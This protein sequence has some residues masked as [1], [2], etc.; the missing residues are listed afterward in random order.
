[1]YK[2]INRQPLRKAFLQCVDHILIHT[3]RNHKFVQIHR[4]HITY[5][6]ISNRRRS[7]I[8]QLYAQKR[9]AHDIPVAFIFHQKLH[10]C[11]YIFKLLHLIQ[12]YDRTAFLKRLFCHQTKSHKQI[13]CISGTAKQ[14]GKLRLVNKIQFHIWHSTFPEAFFYKICLTNLSRSRYEQSVSAALNP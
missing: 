1:M 8:I 14:C 5:T 10:S 9:T 4:I 13:L 3:N 7:E 11:H 6:Q 2:R 12:K